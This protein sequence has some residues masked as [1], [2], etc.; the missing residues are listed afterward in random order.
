MS[1]TILKPGKDVVSWKFG[2]NGKVTVKSVYNALTRNE[3]GPYH[4]IWKSKI[5]A[6]IKFLLRMILNNATLTKDN[7]V[8]RKWPDDP[9]YFFCLKNESV[10]HLFFQCSM[11]KAVWAIT[12]KCLGASN[13]PNSFEQY[14]VW[15]EQRLPYG[16]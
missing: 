1:K 10:T 7:M 2:C 13:I 8:K 12:A 6:K 15:C 16:K 5:P 3:S 9:T 11:A 4:K 14:W